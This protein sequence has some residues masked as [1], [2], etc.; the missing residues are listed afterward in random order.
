M[1]VDIEQTTAAGDL[2]NLLDT[3]DKDPHHHVHGH[4]HEQILNPDGGKIFD[5]QFITTT[6]VPT[7][8][9]NLF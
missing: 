2:T 5:D 1:H 8:G 3:L 7:K 9:N 6:A 4:E